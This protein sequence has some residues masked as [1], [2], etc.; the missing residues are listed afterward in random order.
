MYVAANSNYGYDNCLTQSG[1]AL[2]WTFFLSGGE[3][4]GYYKG[5]RPRMD[6][7]LDGSPNCLPQSVVA[8]SCTSSILGCTNP[9]F[10]RSRIKELYKKIQIPRL[11]K[12]WFELQCF[13]SSFFFL[14]F[15][16]G[17]WVT[18]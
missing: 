9:G 18:Y 6:F 8:L 5:S 3:A 4:C 7:F 15:F 12:L 17:K 10:R 13:L 14:N 16:D 11:L 1:V 2:S